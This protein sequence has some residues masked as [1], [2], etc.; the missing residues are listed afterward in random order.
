[1]VVTKRL[2]VKT[3][4]HC[5]IVDITQQVMSELVHSGLRNGVVT[6]FVAGSTAGLTTIEYEPGLVEDFCTFWQ[7]VAPEG[8]PYN[9]DLRWDEANGYSHVRASLLGPSLTVPFSDGRPALGTWQQIV[10]IDFDNRPRH[11]DIVLQVMGE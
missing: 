9:H 10:V 6:L 5:D 3:Q 7:R 11:R 4:G 8:I 2:E 1:M